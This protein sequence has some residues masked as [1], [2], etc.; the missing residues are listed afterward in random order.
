MKE[1]RITK[2]LSIPAARPLADTLLQVVALLLDLEWDVEVKPHD[3]L[4]GWLKLTAT[5]KT[6][7]QLRAEWASWREKGPTIVG[8]GRKH[9]R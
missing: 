8:K 3:K 1:V 6:A 2:E 7:K 9:G 4:K 5:R